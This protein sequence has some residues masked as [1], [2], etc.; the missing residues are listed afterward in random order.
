MVPTDLLTGG[1]SQSGVV[2]ASYAFAPPGYSRK[3][4]RQAI[5]MVGCGTSQ[6]LDCLQSV[7]AQ[8]L[9]ETERELIV[10]YV[11][12]FIESFEKELSCNLN[13]KLN[14]LCKQ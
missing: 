4:T 10:S 3:F 13:K 14:I 1:I 6:L 8:E 5:K 2:D 9:I 7:S 12:I 11:Y